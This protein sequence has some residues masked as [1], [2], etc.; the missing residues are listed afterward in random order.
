MKKKLILILL[1]AFLFFMPS[2]SSLSIISDIPVWSA[3]TFSGKWGLRE[4]D[5]I[6]DFFDGENGDGMTEHE[7]GEIS[8]YYGKIF[9]KIYYIQGFFYP[10]DN[11][12]KISN[13]SGI[14]YEHF[15]FGKIGSFS[16]KFDMYNIESNE[17]NYVGFGEFNETF[18]NWRLMQ[19]IGPTFYLKGDFYK[20]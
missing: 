17:T 3:G 1:I 9:S 5:Y 15:L 10:Y 13:I 16:I 11:N 18:F 19:N 14:C 20:H 7:F 6:K 8:G 4:Y 2:I 12:S